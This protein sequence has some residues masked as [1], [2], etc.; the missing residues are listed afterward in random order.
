MEV[1]R[2]PRKAK[3]DYLVL[4]FHETFPRQGTMGQVAVVLQVGRSSRRVGRTHYPSGEVNRTGWQTGPGQP[5]GR[6]PATCWWWRRRRRW[7]WAGRT[8]TRRALGSGGIDG[9][10]APNAGARKDRSP[11]VPD[12]VGVQ[13]LG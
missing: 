10:R 5:A 12:A 4:G 6:P 8:F 7:S 11:V 13:E 2:R 9:W 1:R 3:T